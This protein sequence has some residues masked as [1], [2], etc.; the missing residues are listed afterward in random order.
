MISIKKYFQNTVYPINFLNSISIFIFLMIG[1]IF[2]RDIN[3]FLYALII[4]AYLILIATLVSLSLFSKTINYTWIILLGF[5]LGN[6]FKYFSYY[7][8]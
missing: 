3:N 2:A 6:I 8:I 5:I 7:H 4:S 1:I